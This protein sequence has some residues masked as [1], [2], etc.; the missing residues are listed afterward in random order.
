MK[1]AIAFVAI[2]WRPWASPDPRAPSNSVL[3]ATK[4]TGTGPTSATKSGI[5]L[6]CTGKFKGSTTKT[7]VGK[8][9]AGSFSGAIGCTSVTLGNLPWTAKALTATTGQILNVQ[10]NSP[11]GNCGP[12]SPARVAQ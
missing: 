8:I 5:T 4:F 12:A 2:G 6:S 7:G 1:S 10:F 11:I 3:R 9:A